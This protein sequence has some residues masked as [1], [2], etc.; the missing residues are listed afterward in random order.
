MRTKERRLIAKV[1]C[2]ALA[3]AALG[4]STPGCWQP[5]LYP[6]GSFCAAPAAGGE[7]CV[8]ADQGPAAAWD[9]AAQAGPLPIQVWAKWPSEVT[10]DQLVASQ[11]KLA[12]WFRDIDTASF[13]VRDTQRSAESYHASMAGPIVELLNEAVDRQGEILADRPDPLGS[14]KAEITAKAAAEKDPIVAEIATDKQT[15]TA[16]Q[17]VFDK[18]KAD[19]APL[20]TAYASLVTQFTGYR[21]TE[22][23]A[24]AAYVALAQQASGASLADLPGVEQAI[25]MAA[26]NGSSQPVDLTMA[27]MK[28]SAQIQVFETSSQ[29]AIAPYEDFMATHGAATADMTSD[30]LRS[31][32]AMLGYVQQRVKRSDATASTLIAGVA[33]R[34][35]ALEMLAAQ[36]PPP[37][38]KDVIAEVQVRRAFLDAARA[39][40]EAR[41]A[42][43]AMPTVNGAV[44][45]TEAK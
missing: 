32:N 9:Q 29:S 30:A 16:A 17:G 43:R 41:R 3:V 21:A 28:L 1:L 42:G 45:G 15:M 31:I 23:A 38:A 33:M 4:A 10:V 24:T 11:D 37:P 12:P 40:L 36:P 14:F 19:A 2:T 34:M 8:S 44:R 35:K 5:P 13:Y 18:A 25:V 6:L 22:A 26:Q 27:A 7:H 20:S 39:K